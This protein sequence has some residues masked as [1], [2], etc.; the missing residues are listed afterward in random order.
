MKRLLLI[1]LCLTFSIT[2]FAQYYIKGEVKNEKG[3]PLENVNILVQ[4]TNMLYSSGTYGG[5][6]ITSSRL[7]DSLT[8]T[9]DGYETVTI[10]INA[11]EYVHILLKKLILPVGVQ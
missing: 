5:F 2:S 11:T 10:K 8:F 4:S 7:I 1:L 6:G 9:L 3:N